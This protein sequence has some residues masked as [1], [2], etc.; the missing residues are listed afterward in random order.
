M[1]TWQS[2]SDTCLT[3]N[4]II[5]CFLVFLQKFRWI[6]FQKFHIFIC[7]HYSVLQPLDWNKLLPPLVSLCWPLSSVYV[8]AWPNALGAESKLRD[9][10]R[11]RN[12]LS[13]SCRWRGTDCFG[14]DRRW[15]LTRMT[16]LTRLTRLTPQCALSRHILAVDDMTRYFWLLYFTD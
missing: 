3:H 6:S 16:R 5:V 14:A 9:A 15:P 13:L 1:I 7:I 11:T 12:E 8:R 2:I 10:R 4:I